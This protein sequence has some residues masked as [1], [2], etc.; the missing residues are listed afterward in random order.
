MQRFVLF[1][2]NPDLQASIKQLQEDLHSLARSHH[3]SLSALKDRYI[4]KEQAL[5][6]SVCPLTPTPHHHLI[7]ITQIVQIRKSII[8]LQI[9]SA[10]G[11]EVDV[12]A[13]RQ[14]IVD[15]GGRVLASIGDES[16]P[17]SSRFDLP[18]FQ[19]S[20]SG[21]VLSLHHILHF[22]SGYLC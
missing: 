13:L 17:S 2:E 16:I 21:K 3:T 6:D 19:P 1:V 18:V 22:N 9:Q 7:F 11:G 8:S 12:N 15:E 20:D 10:A 4:Q 5:T 14:H